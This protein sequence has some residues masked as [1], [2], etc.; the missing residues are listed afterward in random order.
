[1]LCLGS[2]PA[3]TAWPRVHA[4]AWLLAHPGEIFRKR[5]SR[6]AGRQREDAEILPLISG[7]YLDEGSRWNRVVRLYE[8]VV[9]VGVGIDFLARGE[10]WH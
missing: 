6:Q 3:P 5:R 2:W 10:H 8:R 1:M 7:N 4:W 9:G